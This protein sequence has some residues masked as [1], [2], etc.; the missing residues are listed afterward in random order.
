MREIGIKIEGGEETK[1]ERGRARGRKGGRCEWEQR[2][3]CEKEGT[4]DCQYG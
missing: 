2:R 4:C 3:G 1:G